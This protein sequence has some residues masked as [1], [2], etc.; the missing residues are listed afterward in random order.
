MI[1][2]DN[3]RHLYVTH[4]LNIP[5]FVICVTMHLK[6][7]Q[8]WGTLFK[9]EL[10]ASFTASVTIITEKI[11]VVYNRQLCEKKANGWILFFGGAFTSWKRTWRAKR[12]SWQCAPSIRRCRGVAL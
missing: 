2:A 12:A 8:W 6:K 11:S 4:S 7:Y 9:K 1:L 10:E 5:D 3:H